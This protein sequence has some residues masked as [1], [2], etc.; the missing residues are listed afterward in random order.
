MSKITA[1]RN[2]QT[3][4][5]F[6]ARILN[7]FMRIT[8]QYYARHSCLLPL[9]GEGLRKGCRLF[10]IAAQHPYPNLPPSRG[11]E[12]GSDRTPSLV[13][14]NFTSSLPSRLRARLDRHGKVLR[15]PS[16]LA[17]SSSHFRLCRILP[18]PAGTYRHALC[19][20]HGARAN[21]ADR[22]K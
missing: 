1:K 5:I 22:P 17:E 7:S 19:P 10:L 14:N 13:I 8:E 16:P 21:S 9:D 2:R 11:K 20:L 15:I 12:L 6:L 18:T 4:R 3:P